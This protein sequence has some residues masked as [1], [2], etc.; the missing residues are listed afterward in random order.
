MEMVFPLTNLSG[1]P[2]HPSSWLGVSV[3]WRSRWIQWKQSQC[4][5]QRLQRWASP[6]A[7]DGFI[8]NMNDILWRIMIIQFEQFYHHYPAHAY[9]L[10]QWDEIREWS[11]FINRDGVFGG[12]AKRNSR[13]GQKQFHPFSAKRLRYS[14][15]GGRKI[16]RPR[17][18]FRTLACN[19]HHPLR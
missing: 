18:D 12:G 8:T 2:R 17:E 11:L 7:D 6:Q 1:I 5:H 13:G 19:N 3:V 14:K 16:L 15:G 10:S 9:L 4:R